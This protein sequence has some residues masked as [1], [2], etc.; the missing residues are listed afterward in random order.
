MVSCYCCFL[1]ERDLCFVSD[2]VVVIALVV[3]VVLLHLVPQAQGLL[4]LVPELVRLYLEI[5]KGQ[6]RLWPDR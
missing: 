4:F 1:L 3:F 6:V 5:V 2:F